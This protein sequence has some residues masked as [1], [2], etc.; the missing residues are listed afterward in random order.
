MIAARCSLLLLLRLQTLRRLSVAHSQSVPHEILHDFCTK[1]N[2]IDD[3]PDD[4]QADPTV[5]V[6][7]ARSGNGIL[8]ASMEL[9]MVMQMVMQM[10]KQMVMQM[11]MPVM[12]MV[13]LMIMPMVM[14]SISFW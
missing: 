7:V 14:K 2:S 12:Q 6:V 13:M 5:V 11:V 9:Q 4:D 10:V 8:G 1:C 3:A